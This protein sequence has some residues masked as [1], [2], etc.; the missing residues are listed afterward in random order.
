MFMSL[1]KKIFIFFGVIFIFVFKFGNF[2][3]AASSGLSLNYEALK[4]R[5]ITEKQI[6]VMNTL[7]ETLQFCE[8]IFPIQTQAAIE[9]KGIDIS[10]ERIYKQML[11]MKSSGEIFRWYQEFLSENETLRE[12]LQKTFIRANSFDEKK[13]TFRLGTTEF[14]IRWLWL[15][16]TKDGL[17]LTVQDEMTQT[18]ADEIWRAGVLRYVFEIRFPLPK[19][20]RQSPFWEKGTAKVFRSF[21]SARISEDPL[22]LIYLVFPNSSWL[23]III[24][25]SLELIH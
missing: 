12:I 15:Y 23:P 6:E 9:E 10:A 14:T 16:P 20:I 4:F 24:Q 19:G 18:V 21:P 2:A 11:A 25:R 13:A 3:N 5:V 7:R 1:R 8:I 22:E 17:T